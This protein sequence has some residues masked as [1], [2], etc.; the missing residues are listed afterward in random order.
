MAFRRVQARDQEPPRHRPRPKRRSSS[1]LMYASRSPFNRD[2]MLTGRI[3][4]LYT[5]TVAARPDFFV[6]RSSSS[7]SPSAHAA[8]T[9][10]RRR[11]WSRSRPIRRV[12][13]VE[14]GPARPKLGE[15][16]LERRVDLIGGSPWRQRATT[17]ARVSSPARGVSCVICTCSASL[18]H[19]QYRLPVLCVRAPG[20]AGMPLRWGVPGGR[21]R[22]S[23]QRIGSTLPRI[24][25]SACPPA[26]GAVHRR[27]AGPLARFRQSTR[28]AAPDGRSRLPSMSPSTR[29]HQAQ[30][31]SPRLR[32]LDVSAASRSIRIRH[33]FQRRMWSWKPGSSS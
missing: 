8:A 26:R 11:S 5:E 20:S 12:L 18:P 27:A 16:L 10:N 22:R 25:F 33:S 4:P 31:H 6:E 1:T 17:A 2:F 32:R 7:Q 9:W 3:R 24:R 13:R 29:R 28:T 14:P 15:L 19:V 21:G 23:V 30:G